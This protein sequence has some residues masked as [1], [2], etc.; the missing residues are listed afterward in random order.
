[1]KKLYIQF[2]FLIGAYLT[3]NAQEWVWQNPQPVGNAHNDVE[4]INDQTFYVSGAKGQFL[5]TSDF[6][7]TWEVANIPTD[8]G[9]GEL[10]FSNESEGWAI[11]GNGEIWTTEDA[12]ANWLLQWEAQGAPTLRTLDLFDQIG[13]AAGHVGFAENV[14][15]KTEDGGS[16]W[17]TVSLPARE[18]AFF[19]GLFFTDAVNADTVYAASWDNTFFRSYDRGASWDT[20]HLPNSA[21]GYY[22]GGFFVNDSTGFIVGPNG[23]IVKTTDYGD[24]WDIMAGSADST[25]ENSHYLTE[26]FF[27]DEQTGW[28][29]S[30]GCLYHTT[31][32]G[33][34]WTRSCEGTYGNFRKGFIE[35]DEQGRGIAVAQFEVFVTEN[36]PDFDLVLPV[37]LTNTLYSI[38]E[39]DGHLYAAAS[40]GK[41]FH[42]TDNGQNWMVMS[43]SVNSTLRAVRFVDQ[44]NGWATGSSGTVIKTAD[45]G[46][47]W[48]S[49]GLN[50]DGNLDDLYAWSASSAIVVGD[51]GTIFKTI[52]GGI[53]WAEGIITTESNL[54]AVHFTDIDTG[55]VVGNSGLL[56]RTVDGGTNWSIQDPAGVLSHLNDIYFVNGSTGYAVGRSGKILFTNDAGS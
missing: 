15:L 30:F 49:I 28:V 10:Y 16:S 38:N 31:D 5:K 48:E 34:S 56:A 43:T 25:D 19:Y 6:G 51:S 39:T 18:G 1:M 3:A 50:Y 46:M 42:S 23:Y 27:T 41:I 13:Y 53:T 22:E 47:N 54:N 52:D 33:S 24:S 8:A 11:T 14:M 45:A 44:D 40:E 37:G 32:G 2:V 4:W 55:Y 29:S 36:A 35:F 7:Q 20:I 9:V 26:V 12:G 21:P 17:D